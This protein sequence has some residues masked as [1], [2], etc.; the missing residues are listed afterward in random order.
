MK[1]LLVIALVLGALK[2]NA[3]EIIHLLPGSDLPK[4]TVYHP[5]KEKPNGT[6]V[7]ICPGGG[8]ALLSNETASAKK[9][10]EAGI[11]AFILDYRLPAGNDTLPLYDLRLAIRYVRDH[12]GELK[13]NTDKIG[14]VGFSAGGHLAVTAGTHFRNAEER[15]D[16]LVLAYPVVSMRSGLTN[17]DT[18]KALLGT[19]P[20]SAKV[21]AYSNELQV[22]EQTPGTFMTH[23]MDDEVVPVNNSLFFYAALLQHQVPAQLFLYAHGGH[24]YGIDNN[25]AQLQWIDACI[26]WINKEGWKK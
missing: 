23:A 7:I 8:Y 16:F 21:L 4:L 10:S 13:L 20:D 3:Q 22:T 17:A 25:T 9:S 11:T 18:R 1:Q 5:L 24:G 19:H 6:A 15:P 14:V 2:I 12:A 26:G